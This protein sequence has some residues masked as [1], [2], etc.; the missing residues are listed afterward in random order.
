[1]VHGLQQAATTEE[2]GYARAEKRGERAPRP[3]MNLCI[4]CEDG[5]M[6]WW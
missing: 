3:T 4:V 5:G 6:W 1:M 2:R